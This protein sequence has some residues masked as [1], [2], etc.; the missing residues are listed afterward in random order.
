[1]HRKSAYFVFVAV[2]GLL[3]IGISPL[4]FQPSEIAKIAVIFFLAY[5]FSRYEKNSSN[6]VRGFLVPLLIIVPVL[7]LILAEVDLGTTALIGVTAFVIMFVAGANP[8]L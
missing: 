8:F 5:W 7:C 3:T 6:L 2:L 4:S 1:M